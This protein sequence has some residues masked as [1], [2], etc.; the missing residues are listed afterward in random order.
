MTARKDIRTRLRAA[1]VPVVI[2]L[3]GSYFTYHVVQGEHGLISYI[4]LHAQVAEAQILADVLDEERSALER[5]V[6][7]LRSD[8]LDP[9]MLEVAVRKQLHFT[10]PDEIV[11]LFD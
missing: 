2:A 9:D 3:L 8:N 5:H 10:H 1:A 6:A 7:L 4:K 11:I